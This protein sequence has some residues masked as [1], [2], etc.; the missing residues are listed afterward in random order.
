MSL[1]F[2]L[3]KL[4]IIFYGT[5]EYN[6]FNDWKVESWLHN[7]QGNTLITQAG[8]STEHFLT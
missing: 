3:D 7:I 2:L 4:W 1:Y 6:D 5:V 8:H